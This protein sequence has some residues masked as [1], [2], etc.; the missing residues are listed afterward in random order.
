MNSNFLRQQK[1]TP[2]FLGVPLLISSAADLFLNQS[3]YFLLIV[4][5]A[6]LAE[7]PP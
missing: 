4:V 7:V 6:T 2:N 5:L 3:P 1:G